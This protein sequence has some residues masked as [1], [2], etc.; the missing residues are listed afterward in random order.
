V[1]VFTSGLN[2]ESIFPEQ[3]IQDFIIPA[4]KS[5][6]PL[7]ENPGAMALLEAK[8]RA[9]GQPQPKSVPSLPQFAQNLSEKTYFMKLNASGWRSFSLSFGEKEALLNV[10]T[11]EGH[12]ELP[13]GLDN[14][15]RLTPVKRYGLLQWSGSLASRGF[16]QDDK[17]FVVYEH[18]LGQ[19]DSLEVRYTFI[20][21]R[22]SIRWRE[23]V[24]DGS[25]YLSGELQK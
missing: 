24:E 20:E 10:S 18:V 15:F 23:F 9:A 3:L 5:P 8:I 14:I 6:S 2:N 4:V 22:V 12:F 13:I 21:D 11:R 7:P 1:V 25:L 17:T 16:W 19:A